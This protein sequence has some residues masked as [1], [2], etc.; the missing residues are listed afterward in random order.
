M[1][2]TKIVTLYE[3]DELSDRAKERAR[4]WYTSCSDGDYK[5]WVY[6]DAERVA[7]ILGIDFNQRTYK[8]YGGGTGAEP[9]IWYSGFWSQGDGACFEG[10]Y[11]YKK[12]AT[13][14]IRAYCSDPELIRIADT[15]QAIQRKAFYGLTASMRHSGHYYHSGCMRVEV[16]KVN[17]NG[18]TVPL[19]SN[20]E[21]GIT[22]L[23]RDFADWIYKQLEVAYEDSVS[24]EV[25]ADNIRANEYTFLVTGERED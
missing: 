20:E 7:D 19:S 6:E 16:E 2:T 5:D 11:S 3:Y 9:K 12:G 1:A 10:S 21:D 18:S 8:T 4:E 23:M 17:S 25:V 24:E 15:L 13:K 14:N 22:Q